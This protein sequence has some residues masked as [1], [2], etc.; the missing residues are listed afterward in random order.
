MRSPAFVRPAPVAESAS[1]PG[2]VYLMT[3][4]PLAEVQ[5]R[6]VALPA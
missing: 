3:S 5:G 6:Y 2:G 1:R 4:F